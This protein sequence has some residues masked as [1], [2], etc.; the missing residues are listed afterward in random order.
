M[1]PHLMKNVIHPYGYTFFSWLAYQDKTDIMKNIVEYQDVK[2]IRDHYGN[3]PLL[4]ALKRNSS[5]KVSWIL[6]FISNSSKI[7]K[8]SKLFKQI[9]NSELILLLRLGP[10]SLV[11]FFESAIVPIEDNLCTVAKKIDEDNPTYI[12]VDPLKA[13]YKEAE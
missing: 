7:T 8:S 10:V 9:S 2:Y 5:E 6:D 1:L 3:G 13:R 12:K 11:P 4:Y